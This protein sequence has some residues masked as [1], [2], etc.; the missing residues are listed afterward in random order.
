VRALP[1]FARFGAPRF[2]PLGQVVLRSD[3]NDTARWLRHACAIQGLCTRAVLQCADHP[4]GTVCRPGACPI[5]LIRSLSPSLIYHTGQFVCACHGLGC[6][7]AHSLIATISPAPVR[8]LADRVLS[9]AAV[10]VRYNPYIDGKLDLVETFLTLILLF[11]SASG[12]IFSL[13][14]DYDN[15]PDDNVPLEGINGIRPMVRYILQWVSFIGII[16]GSS[17]SLILVVNETCE[18]LYIWHLLRHGL[19]EVKQSGTP[20]SKL[21]RLVAPDES[22]DLTAADVANHL[23][24]SQHVLAYSTREYGTSFRVEDMHVFYPISLHRFQLALRKAP[25]DEIR[26]AYPSAFA[27]L[28]STSRCTCNPLYLLATMCGSRY[29]RAGQHGPRCF[30][31]MLRTRAVEPELVRRA[32]CER[33][34]NASSA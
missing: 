1:A 18:K 6:S 31:A 14:G 16:A 29:R 8:S 4:D 32:G 22:L 20:S 21:T 7:H 33:L 3:V 30:D 5:P 17:V 26:R 13:T 25:G 9:C 23:D 2:F 15:L 28:T 19:V 34:S 12:L 24:F 10:Q 11:L 27:S